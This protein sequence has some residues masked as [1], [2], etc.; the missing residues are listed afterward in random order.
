MTGKSCGIAG[1]APYVAEKYR[2]SELPFFQCRYI[3][4]RHASERHNTVVYDT[5]GRC[6]LQFGGRICGRVALL[7]YTVEYRTEENVITFGFLCS[8]FGHGMA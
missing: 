8:D 7:R 2:A 6:L 4:E 5:I 1:F 3:V